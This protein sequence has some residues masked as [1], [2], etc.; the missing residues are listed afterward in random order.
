MRRTLALALLLLAG[1]GGGTS[2]WTYHW[3]SADGNVTID[4][5]GDNTS[6]PKQFDAEH[7]DQGD[8]QYENNW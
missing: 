3:V 5:S 1:C 4:A 6:A 7:Y 2:H 8:P